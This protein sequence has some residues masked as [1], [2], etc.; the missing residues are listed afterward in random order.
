METPNPL[1]LGAQFITLGQTNAQVAR[2]YRGFN[3]YA[4]AFRAASEHFEKKD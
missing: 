2:A 1:S 3:G 4:P